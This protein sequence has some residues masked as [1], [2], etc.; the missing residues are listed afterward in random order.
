MENKTGD[1]RGDTMFGFGE[2]FIQKLI[3]GLIRGIIKIILVIVALVLLLAVC[4]KYSKILDQVDEETQMGAL[5]R[6]ETL[7][8]MTEHQPSYNYAINISYDPDRVSG[9]GSAVFFEL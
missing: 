8:M 1:M 2:N 6:M 5:P 4:K 7:S 3:Q 9:K